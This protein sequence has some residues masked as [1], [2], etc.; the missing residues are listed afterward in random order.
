MNALFT[1]THASIITELIS[2]W[3]HA[4]ETAESILTFATMTQVS[5]LGT[6]IDICEFERYNKTMKI[7]QLNTTV[8]LARPKSHTQDLQ[9]TSSVTT[10]LWHPCDKPKSHTKI[11]SLMTDQETININI[12]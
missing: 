5:H 1:Y 7:L 8:K 10:T 11:Q 6:F 9:I 2:I 12:R 4:D 3:T